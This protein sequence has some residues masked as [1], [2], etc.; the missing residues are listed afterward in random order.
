MKTLT[1]ID[2]QNKTVLLR[3]DF[4]VPIDK[5]T[6]QVSDTSRIEGAKPTIDYLRERNCKIIL[7]AH[8]GRPK[9]QVPKERIQDKL[10]FESI[11]PT[12]TQVLGVPVQYVKETVGPVVQAAITELPAGGVLM[13]ENVRFHAEEEQND[14]GFAKQLADLADVYVNDAF[15]AAHRAHASTEGVAH[16]LPHAAGLL[17]QKEVEALTKVLNNP[18]QPVVAIIGGAKISSKMALIKNLLPK[19]EY[20]L[21]GGALANTVLMAQNHTIGKS[22]VEQELAGTVKDLLSNKLR[23]PVDVVV[24]KEIRDDAEKRVVGVGAVEPDDYILDIGPDT[25]KMYAECVKTAKT[26][27]WNGP[28]GVFELEAFAMGTYRLAKEVAESSAYSV[29]GGGETVSAVNKVGLENKISF[30][31][32]G[33]GAMLEFMEGKILPGVAALN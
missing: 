17:M 21:L 19:V 6:G 18:E 14:P 1:D 2:V 15:G 28:M 22:L 25:I 16:I 11:I 3:V 29:L 33:G 27:I 7:A 24:A 30:I 8:F 23:V 9:G 32:T 4:N 10:R 26:I 20:L 5:A 12:I 13:L 31:S